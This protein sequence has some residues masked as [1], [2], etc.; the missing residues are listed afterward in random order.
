ME[1]LRM[2]NARAAAGDDVIHLEIGQPST[3]A[4]AAVV[5]AAKR[6]LDAETLG[7]TEALGLPALRRR[8]A[9]FYGE[10]YGVD[11]DP[12]RVVVTTGSSGALLLAFLAAFDV[13][14]RVAVAAPGYPAHRNIL[15]ALGLEPV[16]I[17]VDGGTRFQPTVELLDR[18]TGR[19][20]GL[21]VASPSNPAGSI[22]PP[23]ELRR[24]ADYCRDRAIRLVSDE[25]YHGIVYGEPPQT[26]AALSDQA[27]VVN[28][29]SKYFSMTGWRLGWM[30]VPEDLLRPVEALAQNL[31]VAPPSLPQ[32]AALAVFDC[33][34]ELDE[35]VR[36]YRRN[37]DLLLAELPRIGLDRFAP[38][39]GAF[40][41]LADV[42]RLTNDSEDFCRRMLAEAGV[43]ATPGT[44]FDSVN[45]RR[46]VRFSF[47]GATEDMAEAMRRLAAWTR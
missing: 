1:V 32:H 19:L 20:D 18:V 31:Y 12:A 24:L 21:I 7:Y 26:V 11:V 13:G 25:V 6:A 14:D 17:P 29:F 16:A 38:P 10:R 42:G 43:A 39:D 41:L 47:A 8:L 28:S 27:V 23:A 45:G 34:P 22:V 30:V 15:H 37:R 40:Y 4:P 44:D 9:R 33:V 3:G 36:R 46:F 35:N 5:A 2:A